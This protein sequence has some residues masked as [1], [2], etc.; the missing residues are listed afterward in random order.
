M[1]LQY[2]KKGE[3]DS[4]QRLLAFNAKLKKTNCYHL[5][6]PKLSDSVGM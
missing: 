2:K 5:T 4:R 1:N 6:S 3:S